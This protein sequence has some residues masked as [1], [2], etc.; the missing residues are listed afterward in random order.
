LACR[1]VDFPATP[2]AEDINRKAQEE[3]E[4]KR[5]QMET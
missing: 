3:H 5:R 4:R 1:R 2:D